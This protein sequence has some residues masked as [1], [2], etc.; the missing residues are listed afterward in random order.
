[1]RKG[2]EDRGDYASLPQLAKPRLGISQSPL[3]TSV[4]FSKTLTCLSPLHNRIVLSAEAN[5]KHTCVHGDK[6]TSEVFVMPQGE[7]CPYRS[8]MA[9][10][11]IHTFPILPYSCGAIHYQSL[12]CRQQ[13][14]IYLSQ[15]PEMTVPSVPTSNAHT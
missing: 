13:G 15:L 11:S 12:F 6:E 9:F 2:V 1:M 5:R 3:T 4:C 10:E 14:V 8:V 7:D